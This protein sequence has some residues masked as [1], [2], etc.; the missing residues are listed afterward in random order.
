M[1]NNSK[2]LNVQAIK[3]DMDSQL[4]T[5]KDCLFVEIYWDGEKTVIVT[6]EKSE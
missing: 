1:K 3:K 6:K 4:T 2:S 5:S